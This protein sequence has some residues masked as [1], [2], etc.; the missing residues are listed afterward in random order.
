MPHPTII[1]GFLLAFALPALAAGPAGAFPPDL[2]TLGDWMTGRFSSAEQAAADPGF[3][4]IR[5]VMVRVW[6]E[7]TDAIWLYVEQA[8]AATADKP[9]RQRIYRIAWLADGFIESRVYSL[10]RPEP[11]AG[12][13]R[14][15]DFLAG[16]QPDQSDLLQL[17]DGCSIVLRRA[18]GRF[19]GSTLGRLCPSELR[20]AAYATSE[21]VITAD[22]LTSWD[23]GFDAA[24][25]QVW[26]AEKGPY[27]FRKTAR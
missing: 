26:G 12:K 5:L 17:R 25:T 1:L 7:R 9:Y 6:P 19:V 24:G 27:V 10:A 20:G 18:G 13:W 14:E 22:T 21:V 11:Y 23:R 4:D 15:P 16:L 8:V 3:K 2:E